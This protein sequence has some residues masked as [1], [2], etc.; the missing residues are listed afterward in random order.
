LSN[1]K[2]K[3]LLHLNSALTDKSSQAPL[4][5][6]IFAAMGKVYEEL[7][8]ESIISNTYHIRGMNE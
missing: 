6:I 3:L 5:N 7:M 1:T 2:I 8:Q 4:K